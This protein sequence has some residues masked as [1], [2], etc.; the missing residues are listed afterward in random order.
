MVVDKPSPKGPTADAQAAYLRLLAEQLQAN[1]A[2]KDA[3]ADSVANLLE[4]FKRVNPSAA[5]RKSADLE[6]KVDRLLKE[7][8]E[9]RRELRREKP[10]Q[11]GKP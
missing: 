8:D 2:A 1:K 5:D 10:D 11:P 6:K 4:H 7:V 3:S 9:L